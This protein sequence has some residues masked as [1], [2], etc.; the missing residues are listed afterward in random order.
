MDGL[1]NII[2]KIA[3]QN[4]VQCEAV[5]NSAKQKAQKI[6]DEAKKS[7]EEYLKKQQEFLEIKSASEK[8]K[9]VSSAE[10]E[11]KRVLLSKKCEIIDEC[12][13][14]ALESM[15]NAPDETYF[16]YV[17]TLVSK[18]ALTGE[19]TV[20]FSQK[21]LDRLPEGFEKELSDAAGDGKTLV[22][23]KEAVSSQG[24]FVISYPEMRVDCTFASLM[25]ENADN[26]KDAINKILF[27]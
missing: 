18:Y 1:T 26:I 5:I 7:A 11:Y 27:S 13:T 17:K 4:E 25:E 10:F 6:V 21:D 9:A 19:G 22:I 16:E 12:M 8:S 14:K 20:S 2:T 3:E 15:C 24:G 23:S